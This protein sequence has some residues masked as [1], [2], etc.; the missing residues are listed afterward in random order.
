MSHNINKVQSQEPDRAGAI[1]LSLNNLSN[2]NASSPSADQ[3]LKYVSTQWIPAVVPSSVFTAGGYVAG[4]SKYDAGGGSAYTSTGALDSYRT[5]TYANWSTS[6]AD[7]SRITHGGL[8]IDRTTH[9]GSTPSQVRF[10]R[11]T[12]D[13]GKY[14]LFATTRASIGTSGNYIEWQW[15]D[16]ATDA[17]LGPRWRSDALAAN[18]VSY[19]IGYI[20]CTTGT[21]TCDVRV[22]DNTGGTDQSREYNDILAALQIG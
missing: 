12:V 4:W 13:V 1:A 2:V 5:H 14:L 21:R 18:D 17:A 3:V 9:G 6:N 10:S 20:E 16:T 7:G 15:L 11:I 8:E 19:G 22:V